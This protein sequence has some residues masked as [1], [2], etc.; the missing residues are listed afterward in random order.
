[1]P[2]G[3][4]EREM[5]KTSVVLMVLLAAMPAAGQQAA[6]KKPN[7]LVVGKLFHVQRM[8]ANLDQWILDFLRKWGKYKVTGDP[9]GVDLIMRVELPEEKT[10]Y[11][12]RTGLPQTRR[13]PA[14]FTIVVF[15]WVTNDVLWRAELLDKKPKK[16]QPEPPAGPRTEIYARGLKPDQLA[17]KVTTKLREYVAELEKAEEKSKQ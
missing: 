11:D 10:E 9:E 8:P 4:L 7:E 1:M 13:E 6:P 14:A 5:A 12:R 16:D 15:D 2:V 3:N 17:E